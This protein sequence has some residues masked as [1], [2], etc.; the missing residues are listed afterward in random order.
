MGERFTEGR[1]SGEWIEHLYEAFRERNPAFPALADLQ[2]EGFAEVAAEAFVRRPS[3]LASFR[4]DRDVSPLRTPSGRVEL[5]SDAVAGF[6]YADCPGHPVWLEPAEWIGLAS[7]YPLHLLTSQPKTRLHSQ[8]D[9][10]ET[11]LNGKV[12][13]R[14][15]IGM[16]P[17]DAADRG[18][19]AGD[20]V[21][22]FN[23]R[24]SCLAALAMRD[25]LLQG[26]VQM[27]TG[28]WWDPVE[29]DGLC[30]AGNPNVLTRDVGTSKLA[31]GPTA[32]TCLVEV[33]RY[34]GSPPSVGSHEVPVFVPANQT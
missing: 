7:R 33:E 20:V 11:S 19:S 14:E 16:H 12:D 22:V 18:L 10:G 9:H 30:R 27:P 31:Q 32:Q 29:P 34:D 21:R 23:D 13:G 3:S 8:W 25:D 28:A 17:G 1:T 4:E 2:A 26:V 6:G 24:G 15:Q 5:Y